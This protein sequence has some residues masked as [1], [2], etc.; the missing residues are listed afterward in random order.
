MD[1]LLDIGQFSG[2]IEDMTKEELLA[3]LLTTIQKI[4]P[5][6]YPT[7]T[8]A[9]KLDLEA[10]KAAKNQV[11]Q[12]VYDQQFDDYHQRLADMIQKLNQNWDQLPRTVQVE[13]NE[14]YDDWYAA[15]EPEYFLVDGQNVVG[16]VHSIENLLEENNA[17]DLWKERLE[18]LELLLSMGLNIEEYDPPVES[19]KEAIEALSDLSDD[20]K[21]IDRIWIAIAQSALLDQKADLDE[22]LAQ[23]SEVA[24]EYDLWLD[25]LS[26]ELA[27]QFDPLTRRKI[28]SKWLDLL[29]EQKVLKNENRTVRDALDWIANSD[30]EKEYVLKIVDMIPSL[31]D[32]FFQIYSQSASLES[33]SAYLQ[34]ALAKIHDNPAIRAQLHD[35]VSLVEQKLDHKEEAIDHMIAAVNEEPLF[36][37]YYALTLLDPDRD[38][39][40]ELDTINNNS[41]LK[42]NYAVLE[43]NIQPML[44]MLKR[45]SSGRS[46][47]K[48]TE[49]ALLLCLLGY[50]MK[51]KALHE[52]ADRFLN[53]GTYSHYWKT[54]P[55][56]SQGIDYAALF[57]R[58][59]ERAHLNE[60]QI[61]MALD[62][63]NDRILEFCEEITGSQARKEYFRCAQFVGALYYV[64]SLYGE[65]G[66]SADFKA[67]YGKLIDRYPRFRAEVNDW[68]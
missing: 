37:R 44:S 43:G 62:L 8:G 39:L 47:A 48:R 27:K 35:Q 34:A 22:T 9:F 24:A 60:A 20:V 7:L 18:L 57:S 14:D 49:M 45:N 5:E 61:Q 13:I 59:F 15:D 52:L 55:L 46:S 1:E 25:I 26:E 23:L 42:T 64:R 33:Q 16:L 68:L 30:L 41:Y 29:Y 54:T 32:E 40:P 58:A 38:Y 36:K 65:K 6:L 3:S 17:P 56:D 4:D 21:E 28:A 67:R 53:E 2:L 63:L 50:P 12:E 51:H 19:A 66:L 10:I 11:K 31:A